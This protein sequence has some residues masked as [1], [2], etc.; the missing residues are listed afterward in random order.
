MLGSL[1]IYMSVSDAGEQKREL[2]L[3]ELNL[4]VVVSLLMLG[5]EN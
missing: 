3:L 2:D 5:A 1:H 4:Q